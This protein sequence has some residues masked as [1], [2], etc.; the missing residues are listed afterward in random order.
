[1]NHLIFIDFYQRSVSSPESI[2]QGQNVFVSLDHLQ[3]VP[4]M[5]L[6]REG[7]GRLLHSVG[8]VDQQGCSCGG[9]LVWIYLEVLTSHDYGLPW[10]SFTLSLV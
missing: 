5:L 9:S 10:H 8:P 4:G 2:F 1:M 7:R 6:G 3:Y